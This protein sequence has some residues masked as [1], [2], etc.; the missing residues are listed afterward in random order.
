M[1]AMKY[2]H[3]SIGAPP[4]YTSPVRIARRPTVA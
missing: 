3:Y 2:T 1:E 4:V